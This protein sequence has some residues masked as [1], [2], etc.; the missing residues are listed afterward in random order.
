[1]NYTRTDIIFVSFNIEFSDDGATIV[2]YKKSLS[3]EYQLEGYRLD[4]M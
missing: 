1:L 4:Y 3:M 2:A